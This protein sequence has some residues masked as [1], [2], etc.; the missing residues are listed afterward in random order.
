ME[1]LT[2]KVLELPTTIQEYRFDCPAF[3][4]RH[5]YILDEHN[6]KVYTYRLS[7]MTDTE[8]RSQ[9]KALLDVAVQASAIIWT[10]LDMPLQE[11]GLTV[12]K[13]LQELQTPEYRQCAL[14]AWEKWWSYADPRLDVDIRT[15]IQDIQVV[16]EGLE[17]DYLTPETADKWCKTLG[18]TCWPL[19][20]PC[21]VKDSRGFTY[22]K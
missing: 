11:Y 21:E 14:M 13:A 8:L 4:I 20:E 10:L 17:F 22:I 2:A 16:P 1:H 3:R 5:G 18:L 9:A 19:W 12:E 15:R 7:K 6:Y